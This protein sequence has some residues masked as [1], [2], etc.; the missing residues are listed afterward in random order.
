MQ[1]HEL[2][3]IVGELEPEVLVATERPCCRSRG[4][5]A[6][7]RRSVG[8]LLR[9]EAAEP[10]RHSIHHRLGVAGPTLMKGLERVRFDQSPVNAA[11]VRSPTTAPSS[12]TR[13]TWCESRN[14]PARRISRSP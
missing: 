2:L 5:C 10:S 9:A 7:S 1:R 14:R 3:A 12:L 6:R 8:D 4:P 13:A 11:L